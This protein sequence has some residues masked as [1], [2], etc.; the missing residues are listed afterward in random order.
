MVLRCAAWFTL[1]LLPRFWTRSHVLSCGPLIR[2]KTSAR[3]YRHHWHRNP[4]R[5]R[6]PR[7]G[8]TPQSTPPIHHQHPATLPDRNGKT[9][10]CRRKIMVAV[11]AP[12]KG[13]S[14]AH[15]ALRGLSG[16]K[17]NDARLYSF[18]HLRR[19]PKREPTPR[20]QTTR[21]RQADSPC[22]AL[23]RHHRDSRMR[24]S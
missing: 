18:Q 11:N 19:T 22:H 7:S 10:W 23:R 21:Q 17:H 20:P 6:A 16:G 9:A 13:R 24:R 15:C 8:S 14:N 5:L 12:Y 3:A 2:S 1:P 4:P